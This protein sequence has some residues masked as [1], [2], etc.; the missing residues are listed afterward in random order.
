MT[1]TNNILSTGQQVWLQKMGGAKNP[2][3]IFSDNIIKEEQSQIQKSSFETS[4]SATK[5][6][7]TEEKLTSEGLRPGE[8]LIKEQEARRRQQREEERR[9]AEEAA[10]NAAQKMQL[11]KETILV[12]RESGAQAESSDSNSGNSNS[13]T[14]VTNSSSNENRAVDGDFYKED[15]KTSILKM[16]STELPAN[17]KDVSG[18]QRLHRNPEQ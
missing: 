7:T 12:Q 15:Q 14:G 11:E 5:T 6:E 17:S 4:A 9:K 13:L 18:D 1:L 8:R 2:A 3:S 16:K 10:F